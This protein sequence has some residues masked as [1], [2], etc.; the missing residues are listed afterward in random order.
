M[1][2]FLYL[3]GFNCASFC[4]FFLLYS[5]FLSA[6][7]LEY[8]NENISFQ[9]AF[10]IP[11]Q[12]PKVMLN[13]KNSHRNKPH[14]GPLFC[15]FFPLVIVV[16]IIP[17]FLSS[18]LYQSQNTLECFTNLVIYCALP[19]KVDFCVPFC[20]CLLCA[21]ALCPIIFP[22]DFILVSKV[23]ISRKLLYH[24]RVYLN[25]PFVLHIVLCKFVKSYSLYELK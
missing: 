21:G 3:I 1:A 18:F 20:L 9:K 11:L 8:F 4:S 14:F 25:S 12:H 15:F 2:S 24:S 6:S 16:L 7:C 22:V 23:T 13:I 19:F 10:R 17:Y 5:L